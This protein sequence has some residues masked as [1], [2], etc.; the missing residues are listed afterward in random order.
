VFNI[1]TIS[2]LWLL[3]VLSSAPFIHTLLSRQ[4]RLTS[5]REQLC[6]QK[7]V[8]SSTV[9]FKPAF[10]WDSRVNQQNDALRLEFLLK[11]VAAFLNADGGTLF[12]GVNDDGR[13]WGISRGLALFKGSANHL[14][15]EMMQLISAKISPAH[16]RFVRIRVEHLSA[17]PP[18]GLQPKP[19]CIVDVDPAPHPAFLRWDR[20]VHFYKRAGN[21]SEPL[22]PIE[23]HE[24]IQ[25]R[26]G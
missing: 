22:G 25:A 12:I 20:G 17:E 13:I 9:E 15:L 19:V 3:V 10:Q 14:E 2:G 6:S 1:F 23:Q 26:W 11:P 8:E 4:Q 21:K 24:Y 7:L 5:L 18:D 16:S